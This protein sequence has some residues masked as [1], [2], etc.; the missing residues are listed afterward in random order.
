[1]NEKNGWRG[2]KKTSSTLS[3]GKTGY[4]KRIYQGRKIG[5]FLGKFYGFFVIWF[6]F[7][8]VLN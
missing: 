3:N 6:F 8:F 4:E 2:L 7:G 1:V 5:N